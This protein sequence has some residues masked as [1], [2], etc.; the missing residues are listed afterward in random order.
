LCGSHED[1]PFGGGTYLGNDG[2]FDGERLALIAGVLRAQ[3][4]ED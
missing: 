4:R 3:K 1:G 2:P